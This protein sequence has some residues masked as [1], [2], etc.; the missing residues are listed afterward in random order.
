M[1]VNEFANRHHGVRVP[2]LELDVTP[3]TATETA[4]WISDRSQKSLLL[5]HN[6]HSAYLFHRDDTFRALYRLADRVLIDGAPVL[7]LSKLRNRRLRSVHRIGSTDWVKAMNEGSGGGKIAFLGATQSANERA[8]HAF[9]CQPRSSDWTAIGL[10]GYTD[11]LSQLAW[12]R[13][14]APDVVLVGLGMPAQEH[15]LMNYWDELPP[16]TYATVGGAIDYIGG[17]NKL[18]PRWIGR[19]GLE[20]VWRLAHEPRRLSGRYLVEPLLLASTLA[21]SKWTRA[22]RSRGADSR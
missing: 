8:V 14:E 12:L 17:S 19:C 5:N 11:Q 7:W 18:A 10:H 21:H 22:R 16:A 1:K 20:W 4:A 6:L 15:F 2:G 9:N 13:D 3:M